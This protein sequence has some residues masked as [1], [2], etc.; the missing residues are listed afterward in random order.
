MQQRSSFLSSIYV[1]KMY[2]LGSLSLTCVSG[3]VQL[4]VLGLSL[5]RCSG[6]RQDSMEPAVSWKRKAAR[7]SSCVRIYACPEG[8]RQRPVLLLQQ[9]ALCRQSGLPAVLHGQLIPVLRL[10]GFF[11]GIRLQV[12]HPGFAFHLVL[13]RVS[14][15]ARLLP[16]GDAVVAAAFLRLRVELLV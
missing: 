16:R 3:P 10:H 4:V 15:A 2:C 12:V 7:F 11:H 5:V 8:Q 14:V 6:G 13:P 1:C 9:A